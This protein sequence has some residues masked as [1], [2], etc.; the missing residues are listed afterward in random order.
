MGDIMKLMEIIQQ[1]DN[2]ME[3][4]YNRKRKAQT[5]VETCCPGKLILER[6]SFQHLHALL[7]QHHHQLLLLVVAHYRTLLPRVLL[8][9]HPPRVRMGLMLLVHNH[10]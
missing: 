8:Q 5:V 9:V 7:S 6:G 10:Q 1:K 3:D 4:M 2:L